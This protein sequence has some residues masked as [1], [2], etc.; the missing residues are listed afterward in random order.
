MQQE[1]RHVRESVN[2]R[3]LFLSLHREAPDPLIEPLGYIKIALR[4]DG[5]AGGSFKFAVDHHTR[6]KLAARS[7]FGDV[8]SE[9]ASTAGGADIKRLA[10]QNEEV[11]GLGEIL[12]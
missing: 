4:A 9:D 11:H 1:L 2:E 10:A 5:K 8:V 6:L 7:R 3:S 12:F